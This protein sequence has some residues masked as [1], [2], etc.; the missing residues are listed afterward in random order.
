ML[1]VI[2]SRG[3]G[4]GY[5]R[6]KTDMLKRRRRRGVNIVVVRQICENIVG[7]WIEYLR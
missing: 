5:R 2:R 7:T 1:I 3:R 6:Y 4:G